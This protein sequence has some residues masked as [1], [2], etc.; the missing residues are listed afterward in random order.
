VTAAAEIDLPDKR[1]AIQ[2]YSDAQDRQLIEHFR[3]RGA[4]P[5]CIAP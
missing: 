2:L 5:D 4:E 1:V 3:S